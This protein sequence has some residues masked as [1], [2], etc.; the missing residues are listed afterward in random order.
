MTSGVVKRSVTGRPRG[1][2]MQRGT[3]MNWVAMARTVTLPS[4]PTEVPKF[5]SANSPDKCSVLGSMRSTLLGGLMFLV[6]AVNTIMPRTA[7]MST[8]TPNAHNSSVP[9]IRRSCTSAGCSLMVACSWLFAHGL[10]HRTAREEDEQVDQ[11]IADHQQGDH[12]PGQDGSAE[13]HDAHDLRKRG[14][15]DLVGGFGRNVG[16]FVGRHHRLAPVCQLIPAA[17]YSTSNR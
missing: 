5:C 12:A 11:Q 13:R 10:A 15:I 4:A 7:A 17:V 3:N 9:R 2:A 1:T 14:F 16:G 6:S 8:P